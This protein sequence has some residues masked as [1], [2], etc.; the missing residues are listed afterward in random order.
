MSAQTVRGTVTIEAGTNV[1]PHELRTAQSLAIAG[2]NVHFVRKSDIAYEKTADVLLNGEL[3]E[4]KAP[5]ADHLKAIER[6]LK[7]ARWQSDRIVLDG[8]RMKK[9][10]DKSIEREARKQAESIPRIVR[11]LYINKK[12]EVI[13][14]K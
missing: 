1:W 5:T 13:D 8:R 6:N 14:I 2:Y 4:F 3:W 9:L 10:S 12:G 7:R 11:L